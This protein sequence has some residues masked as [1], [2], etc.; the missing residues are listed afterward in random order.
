MAD[1][2]TIGARLVPRAPTLASPEAAAASTLA[3]RF[4][5]RGLATPIIESPFYGEH[6]ARADWSEETR[7]VGDALHR[8]GFAIVDF[9]F[10]DNLISAARA[11]TARL[12]EGHD[13]SQTGWRDAASL[14]ELARHPKVVELLS[15]LYGRPAF[16]FQ[17]LNF[18]YGTEQFP[19]S[20]AVHFHAKPARFMCGVWVALED[21][22]ERNGPLIYYPGS[23]RLPVFEMF[24]L[25]GA[26]GEHPDAAYPTFYEPFA[27][28]MM[29]AAGIKPALAVMKRGE[30]VIWLANLVHGGSPVLETGR[31]RF[32]QVTHYFFE[33]CAYYAP[34]DS[35]PD[36]A[37]FKWVTPWDLRSGDP[38]A[39]SPGV[40]AA[41]PETEAPA[42]DGVAPIRERAAAQAAPARSVARRAE[43][44]AHR[45]GL[46]FR[47]AKG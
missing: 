40:R 29:R 37:S 27:A 47:R 46:R 25:S 28:R 26:H 12:V 14:H 10:G 23:H 1:G 17:T 20:D 42:S 5:P 4:D 8:D 39:D 24:E 7:A 16:P 6:P 19:H 31:T 22:D 13:R 45:L 21:V 18:R 3:D 32:S 35:R 11:D 38:W 43:R 2:D 34:R 36:R 41:E 30:A 33:G 44:W 9:Q 15:T